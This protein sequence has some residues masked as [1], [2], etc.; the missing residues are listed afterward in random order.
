MYC[1]A[2]KLPPF[3]VVNELLTYNIIT[4]VLTW[5][6]NK[7][8]VKAGTKA[9]YLKKTGYLYVSINKQDCAAHRVAWL[10]VTKKDPWPYEV[11]HINHNKSDNAFKN[12]RKAT[13][14][15][16]SS[17]RLKGTNNTSGHKS[18]TYQSHQTTNPYV[19]CMH[20][21]NKSHY[22]GSFPTLEMAL[23]A[24]DK[25]GKELSKDLTKSIFQLPSCSDFLTPILYS[26]PLQLI[27]YY[28]ALDKGTDVDQ[29][30]NL[31]KS[32]TVE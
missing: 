31:A 19:V 2:K 26:L 13:I 11:D 18:I 7:S 10:L 4:G 15:Q 16:N 5:K 20:Q 29:P 27:A 30:R 28:T 22:V 1:R 9:G 23:E 6:V 8:N 14:Q 25:K 17:N 32:V 3:D 21:Q 12:L 24:R